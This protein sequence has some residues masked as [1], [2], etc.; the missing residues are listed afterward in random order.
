VKHGGKEYQVVGIGPK[1]FADQTKL[2]A[3]DIPTSILGIAGD[4]FLNT[5][6]TSVTIPGDKTNINK[7]AFRNC[8]KLT[9]A[10]CSG[11]KPQCSA[12]AFNGCSSMRELRIR[13]ISESNNGKKLNGTNAVIKVMK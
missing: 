9:V 1:A 2:T 11:K 7:N 3:V 13:G 4:A 12:D 6:L 10:T 5:G 8:K